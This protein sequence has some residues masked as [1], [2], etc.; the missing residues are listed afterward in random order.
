MMGDA[1]DSVRLNALKEA[2]GAEDFAEV[3]AAFITSLGSLLKEM[4]QAI[5]EG[6]SV[7]LQRLAHSAK[8]ASA[9]LG[10]VRLSAQAQQLETLAQQGEVSDMLDRIA[11]MKKE[12][13]QV[14]AILQAV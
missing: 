13:E 14:C 7:T 5:R 10:A 8:S 4:V 1:I 6:D 12:F 11:A 3:V 2:L 9:N